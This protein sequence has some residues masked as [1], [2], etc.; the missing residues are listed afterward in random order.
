[1]CLQNQK[2]FSELASGWKIL[3]RRFV[4]NVKVKETIFNDSRIC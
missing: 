1:V 3:F 4:R 2:Q